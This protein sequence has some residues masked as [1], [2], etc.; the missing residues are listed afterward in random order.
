MIQRLQHRLRLET[1]AFFVPPL[2]LADPHR[3]ARQFGL[4]R[5]VEAGQLRWLSCPRMRDELTRTLRY[6]A[7]VRWQP[8][9]ERVL[10]TFDRLSQ[11]CPN[12]APSAANPAC[13]DT[14]DQ[15]FID[16]ALAEGA[17]WL[18]TRDRALLKLARRMLT[19]GVRVVT[20]ARWS[21]EEE[22]GAAEAAPC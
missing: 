10:T 22:K 12:P 19:R 17:S 2:Q 3:D 16:L 18:V 13:T 20:P 8:D 14:D 1:V 9:S 11:S 21:A 7:L 6:P 15:V 4:A 5:T